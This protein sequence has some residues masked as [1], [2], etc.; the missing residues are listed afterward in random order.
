MQEI[1]EICGYEFNVE[2][3]ILDIP[4]NDHKFDIAK[5]KKVIG[6]NTGCGGQWTSRLWP[7]EYWIK[8]AKNLLKKNYEVILLGGE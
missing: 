7:I 1:F 4:G 8:L 2:E 5:N 6:L 3:Y